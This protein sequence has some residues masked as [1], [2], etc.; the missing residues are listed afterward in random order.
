MLKSMRQID[1]MALFSALW[2][3]S[4]CSIA[5]KVFNFATFHLFIVRPAFRLHVRPCILR[6]PGAGHTVAQVKSRAYK[7][8]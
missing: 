3:R 6:W 5:L 8:I 4:K 1:S 2:L 7:H